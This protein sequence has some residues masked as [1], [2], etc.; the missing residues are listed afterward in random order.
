MA[1]MDISEIR[2]LT[3]KKLVAALA[4]ARRALAVKRFH[5]KTGQNQNTADLKKSRKE[6]A[7]MQTVLNEK[8]S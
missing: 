7:Q 8:T 3:S 4:K 6:I 5:V 1:I 2:Q